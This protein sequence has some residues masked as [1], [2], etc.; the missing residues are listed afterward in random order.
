[1]KTFLISFVLV[2]FTTLLNAQSNYEDVVYLK[3][4]SIIRGLIIEQVFNVSLKIQTQDRSVFFYKIEEIEKITKEEIPSM[5]KKK[6]TNTAAESFAFDKVVFKKYQNIIEI[7]GVFNVNQGKFQGNNLNLFSLQN[8]SSFKISAKSAIGFG[9]GIEVG[10]AP[11]YTN[12]RLNFPIYADFRIRLIPKR[13][14]PILIEQVGLSVYPIF[15]GSTRNQNL[16]VESTAVGALFNTKLGLSAY[17]DNRNSM[18]LGLGYRF[19]HYE[20][21]VED[22]YY[23]KNTTSF[24]SFLHFISV[25]LSIQF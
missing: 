9:L 25:F 4:G 5:E 23:G 8:V 18:V 11:L 12:T 1:M 24:H 20:N 22:N 21:K 7:G 3:N 2:I 13:F 14:S 19:Q 6:A 16:K 17:L 15:D 10:K